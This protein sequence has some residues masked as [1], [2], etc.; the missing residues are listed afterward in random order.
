M[1]NQLQEKPRLGIVRQILKKRLR[2]LVV[3]DD[4]VVSSV[5]KSGFDPVSTV[6]LEIVGHRDRNPYAVGRPLRPRGGGSGD[7]FRRLRAA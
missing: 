7:F 4:V 3:N 1:M 5:L 6:S 2:I